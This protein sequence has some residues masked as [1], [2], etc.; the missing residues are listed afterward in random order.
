MG[1]ISVEGEG[2]HVVQHEGEPLGGAQ[3]FEHDQQRQPDRVGEQRLLLRVGAVRSTR[4]R[5]W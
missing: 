3:M 4:A 1:A 5:R 2:E